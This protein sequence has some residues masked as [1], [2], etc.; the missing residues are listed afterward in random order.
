MI[1]IRE[2]KPEDRDAIH[3]L[4]LAAF[5]KGPEAALVD[6]LRINC[7]EYIAFVAVENGTVVGHILFTPVTI[8]ASD[9]VGMGLAPMAVLPSHQKKGIGSRLV[10]HGLAYLHKS[11][12]PFVIVLGHAEYYPRFGFEVASNYKLRS[13][14]EGVPDQVFMAIVFNKAALPKQGGV[15]RYREEFNDAL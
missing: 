9:S 1:E 14:W 5:N 15:V 2:E 3:R 13:Q 10:H 8:D 7:E 12:C 11:S 6:R 4:N